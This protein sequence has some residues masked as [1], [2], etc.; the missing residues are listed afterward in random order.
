M[1]NLRNCGKQVFFSSAFYTK[2]YILTENNRYFYGI[3]SV[4]WSE[5]VPN[6]YRTTTEQMSLQVALFQQCLVEK[7]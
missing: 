2:Y 1:P 4:L 3:S 7:E 6:N 5:Q